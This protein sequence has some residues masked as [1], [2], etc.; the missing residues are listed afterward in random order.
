MFLILVQTATVSGLLWVT[1]KAQSVHS[2][3]LLPKQ[4]GQ[5]PLQDQEQILCPEQH[6]LPDGCQLLEPMWK[7]IQEVFTLSS[8]RQSQLLVLVCVRL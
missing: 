2:T 8:K 5:Y 4:E 7:R 1:G 6:V 3:A